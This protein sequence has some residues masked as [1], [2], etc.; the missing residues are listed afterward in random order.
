[1]DTDRPA[2]RALVAQTQPDGNLSVLFLP[3]A[4]AYDRYVDGWMVLV[5]PADEV[6]CALWDRAQR[7]ALNRPRLRWL[8]GD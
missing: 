2:L 3:L 1:M 5:D 6:A 4:D 7:P 8:Q